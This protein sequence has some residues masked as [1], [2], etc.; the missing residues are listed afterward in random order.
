MKTKLLLLLLVPTLTHA[1]QKSDADVL[2]Q[3]RYDVQYLASDLLEGARP[4]PRARNSRW[5]TSRGNSG[6]SA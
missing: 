2:D 6:P 5:T 4:A 1:Q 3:M